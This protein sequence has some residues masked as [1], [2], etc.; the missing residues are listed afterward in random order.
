M[1][2]FLKIF[3]I[4]M[5]LTS[6]SVANPCSKKDN[7][8]SRISTIIV[9][10]QPAPYRPS[11][12]QGGV[13]FVEDPGNSLF[14]SVTK[15]D[16]LWESVL[17][18]I[19]GDTNNYGWYGPI[20]TFDEDGP[21]LGTM[22]DYDLV[23]WNT[24]DYWWDT[25]PALTD[26]DQN[27]IG[28]YLENGGMVWL[29]GQDLLDSDVPMSWMSDYFHLDSADQDYCDSIETIPLHGLAEIDS[30][31]FITICDY[32]LNNF[33]PDELIPDAQAHG[34]LEDTDSSKVIGILY[35]GTGNWI[36]AFWT[37]DGRPDA[38]HWGNWIDMVYGM[39]GAFGYPGIVERS[40]QLPARKLQFHITPD[41]FVRSTT[42]KYTIPVA[43]NINLQVFD[44]IGQHIITLNDDYKH[45]G[46]YTN[47]WNGKDAKGMN[48][49]NGIYFVRLT[50][51]KFSTTAKLVV[52]R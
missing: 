49:P 52:I 42:I 19:Y 21:S 46:S 8:N 30:I 39:L 43:G 47:I 2:C 14:G 18:E 5:V 17:I 1:K 25:V 37:V 11:L 28:T 13:L 6:W 45:V 10:N 3:L 4:I 12:R 50:C 34:V 35:P 22:Q 7:D 15:P 16:S 31:S 36:S 23:I 48:V 41:P 38:A 51:G 26:N 29:I 32:Q 9:N 20:L 27:N 24:Y 44:K 33:W 40:S